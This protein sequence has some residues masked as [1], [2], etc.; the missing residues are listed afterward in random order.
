MMRLLTKQNGGKSSALNMALRQGVAG[1]YVM[2]LDADSLLDRNAVRNAV[3]YFANKNVAGVAA[4][5]RV[6]ESMTILGLLQ[7]IEHMIGYRSKKFYAMTSSELIVGGVASTYRR[8]VLE[9]VDFYDTDTQT[10]DLGL[11]MKV[12]SL[13]NKRYRLVYAPNVLAMTQG[14]QTFKAL[15]KQRYRWKLGNLQNLIKYSSSFKTTNTKHTRM[16]T[17]IGYQWHI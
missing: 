11:S 16:M 15:L 2:T 1:E 9:Q 12:T 5:V 3:A 17:F 8:S 7:K 13:G 10:E 6:V 4:N 14:V